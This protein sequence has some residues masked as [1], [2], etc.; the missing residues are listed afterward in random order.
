MRSVLIIDDSQDYRETVAS[1]FFDC[2][3]DVV[4]AACPKEAFECL[5]KEDTL[6]DLIVCDLHMPFSL[7]SDMKHYPYS[8][9]VGIQTIQEFQVSF[10]EIPLIAITATAPHEINLVTEKIRSVPTLSKP[11]HKSELLNLV[12]RVLMEPSAEQAH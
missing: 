2:N 1:I 5:E 9:E 7:E 11:F 10:P 8:Y 4:S 12:E 3:F 6:P